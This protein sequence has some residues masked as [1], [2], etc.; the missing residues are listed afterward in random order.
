MERELST[1][2]M[3]RGFCVSFFTRL[4][5]RFRR[6]RKISERLKNLNANMS[7]TAHDGISLFFLFLKYR[8][9][10]SNSAATRLRIK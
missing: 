9:V 10:A 7:F 1:A 3:I 6:K 5:K 4:N 8:S 2:R